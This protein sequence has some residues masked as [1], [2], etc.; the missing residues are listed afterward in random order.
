MTKRLLIITRHRLNEN[1]GGS[2]ASKGVVHCFAEL[3]EH[4]SIIYPEFEDADKYIPHNFKRF[5]CHDDRSRIR[6]G[7][8]CYRGILSPLSSFTKAHLVTNFYDIIVIDHSFIA[9][10]LIETIKASGATT[11]TIHHNV[12]RDYQHDNRKDYSMLFRW[13]YIHFAMKAERNCLQMSDLNLTV[14]EHDAKVFKSWYHDICVYNWGIYEFQPIPNR[15][16]TK[17]EQK[18]VFII[19][20]SLYFMQSRLPILEFICRY[21]PIVKEKHPDSHLIIAGRNPA[22]DILEKCAKD[23][24]ISIIPNPK[25]IASL[26]QHANYYI[27]PINTGSGRKVRIMDG[28]KQGLPVLCHE[29]S[30]SGYECMLSSNCLFVYHDEN[31]F[32]ISLEEIL[33]STPSPNKVY[34]TYQANFSSEAGIKRLRSILKQENIL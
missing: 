3:F 2:N 26:V 13:P 27:C 10:D 7:L 24:T 22:K 21:W 29:V 33:S 15:V 20:G 25:D 17:K 6:K 18:K 14:T 9:A 32:K 11:I 1:N 12:E 23:S 28:L 8:D 16:F 34:Q 5:P 30:L 19:T 4:G 31:S